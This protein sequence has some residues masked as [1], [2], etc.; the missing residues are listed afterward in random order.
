MKAQ[1]SCV[2]C[3]ALLGVSSYGHCSYRKI[4]RKTSCKYRRYCGDVA[5]EVGA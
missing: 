3:S 4:E 2:G 1:L 5:A